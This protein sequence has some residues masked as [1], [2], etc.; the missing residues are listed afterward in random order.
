MGEK[1]E[2]LEAVHLPA[3]VAVVEALEKQAQAVHPGVS[4]A[5]GVQ[6]HPPRHWEEAQSKGEVQGSPGE[7]V[8]QAPV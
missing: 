1:E 6:Q 7:R 5:R 8:K 4:R 3:V 2:E